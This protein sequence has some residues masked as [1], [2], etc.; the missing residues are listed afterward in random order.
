M[1][2]ITKMNAAMDYIEAHISDEIDLEVLA[3][4]AY[5]SSF[6]FQRMF[7]FITDIGV[8]EYIRRRRLTQAALDLQNTN[9]NILDIAIKY[10]YEN[11]TSFGRA[12]KQLHGITPIEAKKP[13]VKLKAYPRLYFQISIKGDKS[14]DYRIE[15][16]EAFSVFGNETIGSFKDEMG[17]ISP[18]QL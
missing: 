6:N 18:A 14:M 3:S 16:R 4:K 10:G 1:D 15:H 17:F 2:W 5:C 13:G 7:S 12:F 8:A 11:Q 9:Q